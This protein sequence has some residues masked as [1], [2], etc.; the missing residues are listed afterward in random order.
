MGFPLVISLVTLTHFLKVKHKMPYNLKTV[1][2]NHMV[3]ID[4]KSDM[5][6]P[7]VTSL[8]TLTHF[9]KVKHKMPCNLIDIFYEWIQINSIHMLFTVAHIHH[10]F[11]YFHLMKFSPG[12]NFLA[13][14]E[15]F[16]PGWKP[17]RLGRNFSA[18]VDPFRLGGNLLTWME[19]FLP[20]RKPSR[21]GRNL[22]AQVETFST[23]VIT[24]V[25]DYRNISTSQ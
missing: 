13:W 24:H 2:D 14:V 15:T 21:L 12:G 10:I 17:S 4:R 1:R 19:T 23:R 5:G 16:S 18:W 8:V 25:T 20:G 22:L 6:F 9:L 11:C 7:L 3:T